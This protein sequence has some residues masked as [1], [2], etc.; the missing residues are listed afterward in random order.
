MLWLKKI[1]SPKKP[2][3][4]LALLTQ[5]KAKFCEN[6]IITLVFEKNWKLSKIA[7]NFVHNIDPN[8]P[9]L[10]VSTVPR[11]WRPVVDWWLV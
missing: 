6:L 5:S 10:I 1:L 11:K 4:K 3:K 7:E 9:D 8:R 2:A